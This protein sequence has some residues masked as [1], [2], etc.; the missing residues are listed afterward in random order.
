MYLVGAKAIEIW[1][2]L[3]DKRTE[4]AAKRGPFESIAFLSITPC[5]V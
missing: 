1:R 5:I 4:Y 3:A 2:E